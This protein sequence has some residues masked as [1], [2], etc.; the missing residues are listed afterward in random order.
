MPRITGKDSVVERF[1][2]M[3]GPEKVE[4]VGQ[5]LFVGGDMIKAEA[6]HLITQGSV[7]GAN[8]VVSEPGQPPNED[9]GFLRAGLIVEQPAPLRVLVV[10]DIP[11]AVDLE[12]GT[13][14]MAERP[15]MKPATNNKRKEIVELVEKAVGI[16]TSP[17]MR[18]KKLFDPAYGWSSFDVPKHK[19]GGWK[20]PKR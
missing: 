6:A 15:F 4:L 19:R 9:T 18:N 14:K 5:A 3:T 16:A 11:Y 1:T 13:S 8:H 17:N 2:A 7:S 10:N 12:F 20:P